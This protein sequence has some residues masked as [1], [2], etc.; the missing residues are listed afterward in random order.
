MVQP[1]GGSTPAAAKHAVAV[2][3]ELVAPWAVTVFRI[4]RVQVA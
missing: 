1:M 2:I 4:A 3:V